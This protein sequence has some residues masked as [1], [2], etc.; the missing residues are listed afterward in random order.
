MDHIWRQTAKSVRAHQP[1]SAVLVPASRPHVSR[2]VGFRCAQAR[3]G[4]MIAISDTRSGAR[5]SIDQ[6]T[7]PNRSRDSS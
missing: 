6:T 2:T 1:A 7:V 4:W 3:P 5:T